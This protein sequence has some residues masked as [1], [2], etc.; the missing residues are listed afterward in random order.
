MSAP[1]G[2]AI[3]GAQATAAVAARPGQTPRRP[4]DRR[5]RDQLDPARRCATSSPTRS[6]SAAAARPRPARPSAPRRE[7]MVPLSAVDA[8]RVG[9]TPLAST[10]RACARHARSR[11]TCA[12]GKTLERRRQPTSNGTK[13]TSACRPPCAAASRARRAPSSSRSNSQLLI[14]W[15]RWSAIYIVLGMLY[16]SHVHPITVLSTL[17]SAGVGAVLA[18]LLFQHGVHASSP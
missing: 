2:G 3:S 5:R 10:T 16:E 7:T 4:P 9:T 14:C 13:P 15:R 6:P 12:D 1:S 11:S 18:L 8:L 17:P